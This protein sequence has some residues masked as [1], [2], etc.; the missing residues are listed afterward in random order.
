VIIKKKTRKRTVNDA[1]LKLLND[2]DLHRYK[3][4]LKECFFWF[5]LLMISFYRKIQPVK[6]AVH[7]DS[8]NKSLQSFFFSLSPAY[9]YFCLINEYKKNCRVKISEEIVAISL[10]C[11]AVNLLVI[12]DTEK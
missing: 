12:V 2:P 9:I 3:S 1:S 5:S 6:R 10:Y 11:P 7:G 8:I 4:Y